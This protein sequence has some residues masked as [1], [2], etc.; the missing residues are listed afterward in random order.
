MFTIRPARSSDLSQAST[1]LSRAV[2]RRFAG[3]AEFA[4]SPDHPAQLREYLADMVRP[5]RVPLREQ[6][7]EVETG[8]SYGEMA[9]A[10]IRAVVSPEE[11]VDL[12]VLAFAVP[13]IRPGRATATYLSEVCPGHPFALAVSDQGT[14]AGFTGLRMIRQYAR[15]GACARA[16][17]LV[18]EQESHHYQ[19]AAPVSSPA[20]HTAVALLCGGAGQAQ[21]GEVRQRPGL[22][23]ER[24]AEQLAA[25]TADLAGPDQEVVLIVG[26]GIADD[27]ITGGQPERLLAGSPSTPARI[28]PPGQPCTGV[29]WELA[30]VLADP[31][32]PRAVLADYDPTVRY[33]SL[34]TVDLLPPR[35]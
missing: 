18:V 28:A 29:W 34:A 9:A 14:A 16:L 2:R 20:G 11:P 7:F 23:P 10:L 15:T 4:R 5:Y 26:S 35:Q 12:L 13:D 24:V 31:P 8:H 33:L 17:L 27:G 19:P 1:T 25:D 6:A 30:G 32:A 3:P 21:I 22:A